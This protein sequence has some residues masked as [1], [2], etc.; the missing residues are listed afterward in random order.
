MRF[1]NTQTSS[2]QYPMTIELTFPARVFSMF[3]CENPDVNPGIDDK[4]I[5]LPLPLL[6]L[7]NENQ[8][9]IKFNDEKEGYASVIG[10]CS[11]EVCILQC[12]PMKES[13]SSL[14]PTRTDNKQIFYNNIYV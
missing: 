12:H 10:Y 3:D 14:N 2:E 4:Y 8:H 9:P 7:E 5:C 13:R 11:D 6:V 1:Q